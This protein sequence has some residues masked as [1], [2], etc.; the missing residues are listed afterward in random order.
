MSK[1]TSFPIQEFADG[2]KLMPVPSMPYIPPLQN[3]L[4]KVPEKAP[5]LISGSEFLIA[6]L[7][8]SN[9]KYLE[10]LKKISRATI[11]HDSNI[12]VYCTLNATVVVAKRALEPTK[13]D[14]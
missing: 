2:P 14:L 3:N 4:A 6:K 11:C 10:A 5:G 13:E 9:L 1:E 7:Q 8:A 12:G